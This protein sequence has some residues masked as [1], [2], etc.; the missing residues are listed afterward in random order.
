VRPLAS[1]FF[2]SGN[3]RKYLFIGNAAV[4]ATLLLYSWPRLWSM[5]VVRILHGLA[6]VILGAAMMTLTLD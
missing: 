5:V 3:A 2:H 1:P 6:F 4:I